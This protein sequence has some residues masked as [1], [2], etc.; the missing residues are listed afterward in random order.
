M[1][2]P[3]Y[4][5]LRWIGVLPAAILSYVLGYAVLIIMN[6]LSVKI[7]IRSDGDGG[8]MSV[9]VWPIIATG[10]ASKGEHA[11]HGNNSFRKDRMYPLIEAN[12]IYFSEQSTRQR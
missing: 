1:D 4:Y 8:W 6:W 10:V 12:T 9:Y 2:N 7:H 11:A 3:K 5:W